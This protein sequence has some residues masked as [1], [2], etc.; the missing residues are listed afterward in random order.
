MSSYPLQKDRTQ[1]RG[2]QDSTD[3]GSNGVMVALGTV[4]PQARVRFPVTALTFKKLGSNSLFVRAREA[5][6]KLFFPEKQRLNS[7][8]ALTMSRRF[9]KDLYMAIDGGLLK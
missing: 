1:S 5:F 3:N 7:S 9:E 4:A 2:A 6:Y 8:L